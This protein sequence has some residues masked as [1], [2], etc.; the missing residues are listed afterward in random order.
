MTPAAAWLPIPMTRAM[1][2]GA[3]AVNRPITA[4]PATIFGVA[5][6]LGTLEPGKDASLAVWS[7]DP[8]QITSTLVALYEDGKSLDLTDRHKRLWE[9][10]KN[11]PKGKR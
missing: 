9:K 4:N 6:R 7:G 3:T 5:A 8:L 1:N 11:R 10:Y 2:A